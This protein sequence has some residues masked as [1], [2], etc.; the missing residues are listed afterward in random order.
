MQRVSFLR[1]TLNPKTPKITTN[2]PKKK[3]DGDYSRLEHRL[4]NPETDLKRGGRDDYSR[5][6]KTL[7]SPK[8]SKSG[9]PTKSQNFPLNPFLGGTN[10]VFFREFSRNIENSLKFKLKFHLDG[11]LGYPTRDHIIFHV[12]SVIIN[13][14]YIFL[15][16]NLRGNKSI[17]NWFIVTIEF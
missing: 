6:S 14:E 5:A 10:K 17:A 12:Y 3:L 2:F 15:N 7:K 1:D 11:V 9:N 8:I 13:S 16:L 4:K